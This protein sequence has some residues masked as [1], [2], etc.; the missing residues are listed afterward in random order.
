MSE[1]VH[2]V[3]RFFHLHAPRR[4]L[5]PALPVHSSRAGRKPLGP[6]RKQG[7]V[8]PNQQEKTTQ[9]LRPYSHPRPRLAA[10]HPFA[11]GATSLRGPAGA[12]HDST[13]P[14]STDRGQGKLDRPRPVPRHSST[15][16]DSFPHGHP[17]LPDSRAPHAAPTGGLPLDDGKPSLSVIRL[18]FFC[19]MPHGRSLD[20]KWSPG[21]HERG[22]L[23]V[24]RQE[25]PCGTDARLEPFNHP[26]I[27]P[28]V[29]R[30]G[31]LR[32]L[33]LFPTVAP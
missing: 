15:Q 30:C 5:K 2:A 18:R 26:N 20:G 6:G 27:C 23:G 17:L 22:F 11:G 31:P 28:T 29:A 33:P 21:A 10:T 8:E 4:G 16:G 14:T 13:H 3:A 32:L 7:R 25:P 12:N 19:S 9:R 1:T 24:L